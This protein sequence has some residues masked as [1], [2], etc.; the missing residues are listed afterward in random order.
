MHPR[1]GYRSAEGSE[2]MAMAQIGQIEATLIP[3][4]GIGPEITA[5]T[6]DVL[7]ALGAPFMWDVREAGLAGIE[8]AGDPL[9]EPTLASIR[10]T[11][12]RSKGR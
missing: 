3:G 6:T 11:G 4:D 1:P 5:A 7:A 8:A 10:R 2:G 12:W 9:P